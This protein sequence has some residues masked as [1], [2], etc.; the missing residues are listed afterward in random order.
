MDQFA[1]AQVYNCDD[2]LV[3]ARNEQASAFYVHRYVVEVTFHLWQ[4]DGLDQLHRRA[5]LSVHR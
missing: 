4:W 2:P 1:S 5:R 3:L